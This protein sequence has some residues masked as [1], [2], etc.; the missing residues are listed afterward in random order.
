MS[1]KVV[2]YG[3]DDTVEENGNLRHLSN[4]PAAS[5]ILASLPNPVFLLDAD[6]QFQ[7]LNH[8]AEI[9]FQSSQSIIFEQALQ[10][11]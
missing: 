3:R 8:A 5:Q 11:F 10:S 1:D 9:F 4:N 7:F 2:N 6:N